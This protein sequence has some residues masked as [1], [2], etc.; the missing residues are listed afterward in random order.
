MLSLQGFATEATAFTPDAA[1]P[2]ALSEHQRHRRHGPDRYRRRVLRERHPSR[3]LPL[4]LL[5][6]G[7]RLDEAGREAGG[8]ARSTVEALKPMGRCR[9]W[10]PKPLWLLLKRHVIMTA[11]PTATITIAAARA[12]RARALA[13]LRQRIS[14]GLAFAEARNSPV[15]SFSPNHL[16]RLSM[17]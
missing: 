6:A 1:H 2:D 17:F 7:A 12:T 16:R 9:R 14:H 11:T 8:V 13:I 10:R 5:S 15:S 3:P 4:Q